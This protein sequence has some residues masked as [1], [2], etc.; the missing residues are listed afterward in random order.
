VL[1][2][3]G[4]AAAYSA[5]EALDAVREY[6]FGT[7]MIDPDPL[8]PGAFASHTVPRYAYRTYD[9][10]PASDGARFSDLDLLVIAGLNARIDMT[11]FA[12]LRSFADRAADHL[13][14]AHRMQPDFLRLHRDE[15]GDDPP[16]G[17]AGWH[18][19]LAWRQGMATPGLGIARVH[20][21]LHHKRP[22]LVP[23]LD[24]ETVK[25]IRAAADARACGSWQLIHDEIHAHAEHFQILADEFGKLAAGI[26]DVSLSWLR[27]YDILVWMKVTQPAP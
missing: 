17:S 14:T 10:V 16:E 20:K 27:L 19:S 12:R 25:P 22:G 13:D 26:D 9:C 8:F 7:V 2:L 3:A 15:V 4:G 21:T 23:L 18:L 24:N 5:A 1:S 6:A 11:A